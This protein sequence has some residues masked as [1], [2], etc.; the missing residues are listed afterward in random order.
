MGFFAWNCLPKAFW[1]ILRQISGWSHIHFHAWTIIR[2][3]ALSS[4]TCSFHKMVALAVGNWIWR[5]H[6]FIFWTILDCYNI[7]STDH[8]KNHIFAELLWSL[9]HTISINVALLYWWYGVKDYRCFQQWWM[10]SI[11][12]LTFLLIGTQS[13]GFDKLLWS[14]SSD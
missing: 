14:E 12:T 10:I 8:A 4:S 1:K 11:N 5:P 9:Y 13:C 2:T 7:T 6:L 3:I